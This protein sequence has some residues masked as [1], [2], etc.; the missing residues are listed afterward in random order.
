MNQYRSIRPIIALSLT[1]L[2]IDQTTAADSDDVD[3]MA[4]KAAGARWAEAY[5]RDDVEAIAS[6][7]TDDAALLPEGSEAVVGR[8]AILEFFKKMK[9][10]QTPDN[11][12]F[13]NFEFYGAS[14]EI[15]EVSEVVL[16]HRE[17]EIKA[18]GKQVLVRILE[19]GEWKIHRDIWTFNGPNI[20]N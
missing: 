13:R 15:T 19:D 16:R 5:N 17:G 12:S 11:V 14:P 6:M 20:G 3:T 1:L 4:L 2:S 18:V 7:Y 8:G 10:S 9:S